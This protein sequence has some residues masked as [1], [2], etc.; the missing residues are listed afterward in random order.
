MSNKKHLPIYG[1]GPIYV[2]VIAAL[3]S[4]AALICDLPLFASGRLEGLHTVLMI[5]GVV[6]IACGIALWI[7]TSQ[8]QKG[9]NRHAC[10]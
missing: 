10:E 4:A 2:C 6:F 1:P 5:L 9:A 8:L 3:T 7:H